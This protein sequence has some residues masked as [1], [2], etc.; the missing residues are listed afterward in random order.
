[1]ARQ[2]ARRRARAMAQAL[3]RGP[4]PPRPDCAPQAR[5]ADGWEVAGGCNPGLW[6]AGKTAGRAGILLRTWLAHRPE[7]QRMVSKPC[8]CC[9]AGV[10]PCGA[11]YFTRPASANARKP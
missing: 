2:A 1:M 4:I 11:V 8:H 7:L 10:A 9:G 6:A 3:E 5:T